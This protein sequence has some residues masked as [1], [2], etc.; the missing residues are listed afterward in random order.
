MPLRILPPVPRR[1]ALACLL[2]ALA[3]SPGAGHAEEPAPPVAPAAPVPP[4]VAQVV[5]VEA[6]ARDLLS[7]DPVERARGEARLLDALRAESQRPALLS[8]LATALRTWANDEGR[9]EAL[10]RQRA[11]ASEPPPQ[12]LP[13]PAAATAPP[14]PPQVRLVQ[15]TGSE[16]KQEK[17]IE[18]AAGPALFALHVSAISVPTREVGGLLALGAEESKFAALTPSALVQSRRGD[19]Q[20]S[21]AWLDAARRAPDAQPLGEGDLGVAS[22]PRQR[23]HLGAAL[24]YRCCVVP[25]KGGAWAVET[26][27]IEAGLSV[28]ALI[29]PDGTLAL[30]A[31]WITVAQPVSTVRTRVAADVD[32]VELDRPD[33]SLARVRALGAVSRAA[34]SWL[35]TVPGLLP[36]PERTLALVFDV[37]PAP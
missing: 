9:L 30:D 27:E 19:A 37:R 21:A 8:R 10:R 1:L 26:D 3:W 18:Q 2:G 5:D 12:A 25:S 29:E 28:E 20:R 16:P 11:Q 36:D 33:W 7:S 22:G 32:P 15:P 4:P 17:Q 13:A 23:L 34:Q 24:T 14:A 35:V 6:V 31:V